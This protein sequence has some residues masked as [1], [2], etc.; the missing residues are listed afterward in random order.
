MQGSLTHFEVNFSI[1]W[2]Y[3]ITWSRAIAQKSI[4]S[5]NRTILT[6]PII[7]AIQILDPVRLFWY[8]LLA[9]AGEYSWISGI[10][11]SLPLR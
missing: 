9:N 6:S 7:N 10:S 3:T 4:I 1:N 8:I 11:Q 2:T 5:L